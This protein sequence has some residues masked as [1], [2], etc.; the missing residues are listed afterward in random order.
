MN[1]VLINIEFLVFLYIVK[2][3]NHLILVKESHHLLFNI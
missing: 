3:M 2:K 1:K